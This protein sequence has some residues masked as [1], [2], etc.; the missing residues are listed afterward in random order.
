V[1]AFRRGCEETQAIAQGRD[2]IPDG[3][4]KGG[5]VQKNFNVGAEK[6]SRQVTN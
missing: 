4:E 1:L 6:G 2:R 5:K 3:N